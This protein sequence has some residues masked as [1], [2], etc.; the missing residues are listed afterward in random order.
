MQI[1]I[2]GVLI[3]HLK[4]ISKGDCRLYIHEIYDHVVKNCLQDMLQN[5]PSSEQCVIFP[6][7]VY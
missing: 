7:F 6:L 3:L 4:N 1:Y 2:T 5:K